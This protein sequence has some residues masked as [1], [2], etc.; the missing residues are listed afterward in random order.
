MQMMAG[1]PMRGGMRRQL[2]AFLKQCALDYDEGIDFTI[3]MVE[4]GEIIAT[5]SLD[6]C[7]I[8]CVAVSPLRQGEDLCAG[9]ITELR[10]EAFERGME[11]LMLFTKPGNQMMF[12]AFGFYPLVRTPHC[13]LM[14]D[15]RNGLAEFLAGLERPEGV[16]G[17]IGCIV[18]NC[19][20]F[21]RGHRYL[22]ETAAAQV[23]WLHVFILSEEKSLFPADMRLE[24]ARLGCADL[25][26]VSVHASGPYM[27]SSATFPSYF[28]RDKA[29]VGEIYSEVDVRLFG[30]RIAPA[31]GISHRFVGTEPA[32]ATTGG[33]NRN[34]KAHLPG[35]GV[36][37]V[38]LERLE[39][40]GEAVSASRVRAL[41]EAGRKGFT[42]DMLRRLEAL[43]PPTSMSCLRRW[44]ARLEQQA[45]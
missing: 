9:I 11:R 23:D 32:S 4:D 5:G 1:R 7:T 26:N 27:V 35:Y 33:Y 13:L 17:R 30:E 39:L 2:E 19:N 28:I 43:V 3:A 16:C 20:P 41:L 38:E 12:S 10:R 22:I 8:R 31:L 40:D 6:G 25:K 45:E 21:T 44:M 42:D 15:R 36:E 14:E 18:A 34:L 24:M 37:L 29:R